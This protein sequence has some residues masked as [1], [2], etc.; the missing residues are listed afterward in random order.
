MSNPRICW[1]D[2]NQQVLLSDFGISIL[3]PSSNQLST[4][5]N[6]GTLLYMA[7][8]QI[9]GKPV[10]ASDQY[11][12]GIVTYEW[13]CGVRPF[14][15]AAWLVAYQKVS[16]DPPRLHER[17]SSL[18]QAV[19]D[20]VLKALA[21]D[22]QERY[23]SVQLFAQAFERACQENPS[24][25]DSYA[26][27]HGPLVSLSAARSAAPTPRRVFL[28]ASP[29][30]EPFSARLSMDIQKR[31]I[32]VR[33]VVDVENAR[34][35]DQEN[36]VRQ[37]IRAADM[38]FIVVS[39]AVASSRSVNE[40]LR[41]AN[42][43]QR[44]PVFV[45]ATGEEIA[46][47]LLQRWGEM[48]EI[49]LVDARGERYPEALEE[50][51][52]LLKE[53]PPL[54]ELTLPEPTANP[55]NPYKGLRAFTEDDVADFFGRGALIEE[56]V[57]NVR[58]LLTQEQP[59]SHAARLLAVI[60]PSGSGKSSAV[61]AGLLPRLQLGALPASEQ[62]VYLQP[63]VPGSHPLEALALTC[64]QY[65]PGR[66]VKSISEDLEDRTARGLLGLSTQLVKA[67][68]QKVLLLFDQFEEVF[69]LTTSE[70]ERMQFIEL[71]VT[72]TREPQG[73]IIVLLTLRA[74]FY[75]QILAYSELARLIAR[76][77]V[78]V[79]PM[80]VQ[81][82][83]EVIRK[84]TAL[85]DV[86]LSFE[87]NLVGDLLFEVQGQV[88]AL[89]LLEFTLEQLFEHRSGHRL[90]LSAYREIGG[91]KGALS[92]HAERTY[93]ALP[94]DEHRRR[95]RS[96]FVRLIDPGLSEQDTMRRRAAL[97]EF[98]L[99]DPAATHLLQGTVDTFIAARLLTTNEIAGTTTIEVSH[100]ALIREWRRLAEWIGEAREDLYL[101]QA[102]R[103]DAAEWQR[104]QQSIDRLYRGTQLA[105]ALAWRDRSLLSRDEEA[106]LQAS[107]SEQQ[108]Q[109]A[110]VEERQ[111]QEILQRK[112]YTRRTV[113]VGL[114]GLGMAGTAAAVSSVLFTRNTPP[115]LLRH[116]L[117][118]PY[119]YQ[120]HF[121]S[122]ESVAW[123]PDG[124]YLASASHDKTVQVWDASSATLLLTYRGHTDIVESVAWSPDGKRIASA[125]YDKTVQV[126]DATSGAA[127]FTHS[128]Q[129]GAVKSVAWSPNGKYLASASL[130][131]T[132]EVWDTTNETRLFSYNRHTNAVN[133]VAWSPDGTRLASTSADATVQ[134]W[135]AINGS[136]L[137]TYS[138]HTDAV[139]SV[140]WSPDGKYLASGS[141]DAT[142]QVWDASSGTRLTDYSRHADAVF[143]VAWSPDGKRLASASFDKT[144]QVW[145]STSGTHLFTYSRHT[146]AVN[147]VAW[148]P[149]G[150]RIA[151]ASADAT[152]QVW[153]AVLVAG[154]TLLTYRGHTAGVN[155]VAWSPDGKR[156]A[157]ASA[158]A[159]VQ[160]WDAIVGSTLLTYQ[161]HSNDVNSVAWSPDGKRIAS[162]S[163][164]FFPAIGNDYTVQVWDATSGMRLLTYQGHSNDVNSVAWS[165]D[166]KRIASGSADATVQ[167][168][169]AT[170]GTTLLHYTRHTTIVSS[171]A[172][173]PD[174]KYLASASQDST[175]QVWNAISGTRLLTYRGHAAGVNS[176]TW[177]PDGKYLTS[178]SD[179]KTVQVWNA[180]VGSTLLTYR[181]HTAGVNSMAWSPDGMRLGS[182]SADATVRVWD[183]ASG[184]TLL[185][186]QGHTN[187]VN[188]AAWSP[189]GTFLVSASADKTVKMWLW[190][191]S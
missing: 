110:L 63:I 91:L 90:T 159:T 22:P 177:S 138:R 105:E 35:L 180:T 89:P 149:D 185:I 86:Q 96:L 107:L 30:D 160:V 189:D 146:D 148:S 153:D 55:R 58:G 128:R 13:L 152:V 103:E 94:S 47:T 165:P 62:W 72:A 8:E 164:V 111:L 133:S 4:W 188:D 171:V 66:S 7:P 173:S 65:L 24:V 125:S 136:T 135:N 10:F 162:G 151:S 178:G 84:P 150:K 46:E 1:W 54:E 17:D 147:S 71:L 2:R 93:A 155:S 191:Q 31:G 154:K 34:Q 175:V 169:D 16:V 183:T 25:L 79:L 57:E 23:E 37:G 14:E 95:A 33:Q 109:Q 117:P 141:D 127:L 134:V 126:W 114:V 139:N 3:A 106:F 28:S 181:G 145:N 12:L 76:H 6:A 38:L 78:V 144:V 53:E 85:P 92:Q 69:R 166:G 11:A 81:D 161:G 172:W 179:D 98:A 15:G 75:D 121:A 100:E 102:I 39:P 99:A 186:Y 104:Y 73:K 187:A 129:T 120:G 184:A 170:S 82:L 116:A 118:L 88:G 60:G 124:K 137:L 32:A 113:L 163:G 83:R 132:V 21:R 119:S 44:R 9:Q 101:L 5:E 87:G 130:D 56:L 70:D 52:G 68:E 80:D 157:S 27:I 41:I 49:D 64:A 112:R 123:S 67:E 45:W 19:E 131:A 40:Y 168:F 26:E 50:L 143:G 190:L 97:T 29:A 182:A 108:Q 115:P 140:A 51:I 18:P 59:G 122:V 43:Y 77:Q 142:V 167:V 36:V 174:G 176:V 42:L 156:I 158:D 20:V 48:A 61:M 74:D